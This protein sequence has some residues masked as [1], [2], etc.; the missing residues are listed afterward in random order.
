MFSQGLKWQYADPRLY[1]KKKFDDNLLYC[2]LIICCMLGRKRASNALKQPLIS[3]FSM[4]D[5]GN[6]EHILVMKT[7]R[8]GK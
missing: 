5:L 8:A 2:M 1:T 6:A 3:A 7:K 4:K